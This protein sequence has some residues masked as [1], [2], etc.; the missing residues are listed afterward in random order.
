MCSCSFSLLF[1]FFIPLQPV[2]V[3]K[4]T[5]DNNR[6]GLYDSVKQQLVSRPAA[7][8]LY[9]KIHYFVVTRHTHHV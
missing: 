3:I 4:P 7:V 1:S 5:N 2:I 8:S 9:S 6:T